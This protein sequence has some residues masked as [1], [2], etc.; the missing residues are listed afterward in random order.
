M[1][2][3]L[4]AK[5]KHLENQVAHLRY[6]S[7]LEENG[8][9]TF[10]TESGEVVEINHQQYMDFYSQAAARVFTG[11]KIEHEL[12]DEIKRASNGIGL[13]LRCMLGEQVREES[14]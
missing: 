13:Y 6:K 5:I 2:R 12:L 9:A 7:V 10:L 3:S 8:S 4:E 1:S 11:H 14:E